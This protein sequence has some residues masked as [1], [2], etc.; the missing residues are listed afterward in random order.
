[1]GQ[2]LHRSATTTEAIRRAIQHSQ[3]S[4]RTL[5]RRHGINLKTVAKWRKRSSTA[6]AQFNGRSS[7]WSNSSHVH[8]LVHRAKGRHRCFS[9]SD[10]RQLLPL[11]R[12]VACHG[13]S[14]RAAHSTIRPHER[15][16]LQQGIHH[17]WHC[18]LVFCSDPAIP[19]ILRN[20]VLPMMLSARATPTECSRPSSKNPCLVNQIRSVPRAQSLHEFAR[21][22]VFDPETFSLYCEYDPVFPVFRHDDK[23]TI[24]ETSSDSLD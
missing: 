19:A 6:E 23:H 9:L 16:Y 22:L 5:S 11:G 17:A 21:G 13:N 2:I 8:R 14:P 4:L 3:E 10:Q 15:R 7:N 18:H 24:V 1:M 20:F 12:R